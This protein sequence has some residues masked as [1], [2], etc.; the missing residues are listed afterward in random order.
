MFLPT[1]A[2][3]WEYSSLVRDFAPFSSHTMATGLS[4][5]G[6]VVGVTLEWVDPTGPQTGEFVHRAFVWQAGDALDPSILLPQT[7][8]PLPINGDFVGGNPNTL[9]LQWNA[10]FDVNSSG[11]IVGDT[12][13][14]AF[15]NT[16]PLAFMQPLRSGL[17]GVQTGVMNKLELDGGNFVRLNARSITDRKAGS[18]VTVVGSSSEFASASPPIVPEFDRYGEFPCHDSLTF[19]AARW[20]IAGGGVEFALLPGTSSGGEPTP[21]SFGI[22]R[23]AGQE[24][25]T[26]GGNT[27]DVPTWIVGVTPQGITVSDPCTPQAYLPQ[28]WLESSDALLTLIYGDSV[29]RNGAAYDVADALIGQ[30]LQTEIVGFVNNIDSDQ[31]CSVK[32][33][34][35]RPAE[36]DSE[37]FVLP[38]IEGPSGES[39]HDDPEF[40]TYAYATNAKGMIVGGTV[41]E[42]GGNPAPQCE[43][44]IVWVGVGEERD[45]V[46]L[47]DHVV[48][49][50][51]GQ[52]GLQRIIAGTDVNADGWITGVGLYGVG[53]GVDPLEVG[54]LLIPM[55]PCPED[56]DQDG[57]V[58]ADDLAIVRAYLT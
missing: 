14:V 40:R 1:S 52:P 15:A 48:L 44:G 32:A 33:A 31:S 18:Q 22:N 51:P 25:T 3:G 30:E 5:N 12:N 26:S 56:V 19:S 17:P 46:R 42:L 37:L 49:K 10:A 9:Q 45:A 24:I 41:A 38:D 39:C 57:D 36:G 6:I 54:V 20:V 7:V 53:E 8:M 28:R 13:R 11:D 50:D 16:E 4:D 27:L 58:D 47:S 34:R 21:R 55:G 23:R 35:W 2:P 43:D 29:A